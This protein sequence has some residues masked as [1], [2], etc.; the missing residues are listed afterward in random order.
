MFN[1][2]KLMNMIKDNPLSLRIVAFI[3]LVIGIGGLYGILESLLKERFL[4]I[5]I[6]VL[7][8]PVCYGLLKH[9]QVWRT[10][11][12][13][14]IWIEI[15]GS[16]IA[17]GILIFN[18]E[19]TVFKLFGVSSQTMSFPIALVTLGALLLL[20]LWQNKVLT[21]KNIKEMF[22]SDKLESI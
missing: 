10:L 9:R 20:A 13:I 8:L 21:S 19:V 22:I 4:E 16:L 18:R 17:M 12:F 11:A 3:F 2:E 1:T 7:G 6:G 5:N 14:F 15:I